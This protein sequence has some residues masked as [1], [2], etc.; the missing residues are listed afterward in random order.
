MGVMKNLNISK[1]PADFPFHV[2]PVIRMSDLAGGMHV[3]NHTL[4]AFITEAQ[5]QL[6]VELGFPDVVIDG[7]DGRVMP[8]NSGVEITYLSETS[9]GDKIDIGITIESFHEQHYQLIFHATNLGSGRSVLQARMTMC[10]IDL[11]KHR[12]TEVPQAFVDAWQKLIAA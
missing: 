8:I 6:M 12:R 7:P 5:L 4:L 9:Y 3:S 2:H 10:F 1:D 11:E